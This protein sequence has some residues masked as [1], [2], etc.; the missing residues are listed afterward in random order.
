MGSMSK[1]SLG[2]LAVAT[3]VGVAALGSPA[4]ALSQGGAAA[5]PLLMPR[6]APVCPHGES[7]TDVTIDYPT[8]PTAPVG[9]D[10][11]TAT[12]EQLTEYGMPPRPTGSFLTAW[13]AAMKNQVG[14][15]QLPTYSYTCPMSPQTQVPAAESQATP[16]S[17][18]GPVSC[19]F[20]NPIWA[21]NV[22]AK[23]CTGTPPNQNITVYPKNTFTAAYGEFT[24]QYALPE[25]TAPGVPT[26]YSPWVGVGYGISDQLV[27]AGIEARTTSGSLLPF[28]PWTEVYPYASPVY[29]T[30]PTQQIL[31]SDLIFVEVSYSGNT[32]TFYISDQT[33]PGDYHTWPPYKFTGSSGTAA[34]WVVEKN[35]PPL[36]HWSNPY[37]MYDS[38][39]LQ[40]GSWVCAGVPAHVSVQM[41]QTTPYNS[42]TELA[43]GGA[44]TDPGTYCNFPLTR[45]GNY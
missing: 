39:A 20:Q 30:M 11:A 16:A 18:P 42:S 32:A 12:T 15:P 25:G 38:S 13:V 31:T 29:R 26:E 21:G 45:T 3:L 19:D 4:Q 5:A 1:F 14:H 44:W 8:N 22:L 34:E 9:F 41:Y 23:G 2:A 35:T 40:N 37:M 17:S 24:A 7:P 33:H 27:Q 10:P 43:Y 6:N 36:S 28:I